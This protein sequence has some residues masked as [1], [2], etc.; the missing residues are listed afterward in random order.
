MSKKT[1]LEYV[2]IEEHT[3]PMVKSPSYD[4]FRTFKSLEGV[5]KYLTQYPRQED[6]GTWDWEV[7]AHIAAC[8]SSNQV[9]KKGTYF[10]LYEDSGE[11]RATKH[12]S[13]SAASEAAD[14]WKKVNPFGEAFIAREL[15][16]EY[17][18]HIKE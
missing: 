17:E 7:T 14:R 9:N 1:G 4:D 3:H 2:V 18:L 16:F 5:E 13:L 12:K 8:L 6:D 10:V 15:E 11:K